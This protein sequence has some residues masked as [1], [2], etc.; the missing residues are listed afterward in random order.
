MDTFVFMPPCVA[1]GH[2]GFKL[3][4]L[5]KNRT[6]QHFMPVLVGFYTRKCFMEICKSIHK[7]CIFLIFNIS[8]KIF[9][10]DIKLCKKMVKI[11]SQLD[12]TLENY[13]KRIEYKWMGLHACKRWQVAS[14]FHGKIYTPT[15][16]C[17]VL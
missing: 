6:S 14:C 3:Q 11:V 16:Q 13:G 15:Y 7:K 1:T 2:G 8:K 12:V 9:A 5:E 17:F 4:I 10:M